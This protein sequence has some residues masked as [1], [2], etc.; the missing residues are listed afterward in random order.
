MCV[1][2]YMNGDLNEPIM[3]ISRFIQMVIVYIG[4]FFVPSEL[5]LFPFLYRLALMNE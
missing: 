5:F 2:Y 3:I 4:T 1:Q